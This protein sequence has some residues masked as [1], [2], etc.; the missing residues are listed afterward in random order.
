M[1]EKI[2][3]KVIKE[4]GTPTYIFD[5]N[6]VKSRIK[7]LRNKLPEGVKLCYAIKANT[8]IIKDI[9]KEIDRFE[10]CSPG[11]YEICKKR[12][13]ESEKVLVT[14]VYKTPEVIEDIIRNT[15]E[16]KYFTVDS[17]EQFKLLKEVKKTRKFKLMLRLTSGNQFGINEDD[18]K[19][20]IKDYFEELN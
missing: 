10:V 17:N 6:E 11:E 3:S 18:I 13:I 4:F 15:N 9:E 8:F 7:Y 20:I 19:D 14:G 2:L 16:T 12:N 5:I 1:E